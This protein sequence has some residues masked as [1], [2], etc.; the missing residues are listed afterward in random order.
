VE[1]VAGPRENIFGTNWE[2]TQDPLEVRNL[3]Y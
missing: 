1:R 3:M 2:Y